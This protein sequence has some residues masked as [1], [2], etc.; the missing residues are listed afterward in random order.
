[1]LLGIKYEAA[2]I[3]GVDD[4]TLSKIAAQLESEVGEDWRSDHQVLQGRNAVR[5]EYGM[6]RLGEQPPPPPE[7]P[8]RPWYRRLF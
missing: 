8:S 2:R 6:P 5:R 4:A 1:M 3:G 7:A